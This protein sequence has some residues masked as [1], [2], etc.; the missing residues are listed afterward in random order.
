MTFKTKTSL[1]AAA[2]LT[3]MM[4]AACGGDDGGGEVPVPTPNPNN[5]SN[6]SNPSNPRATNHNG[7]CLANSGKFQ[8]IRLGSRT[9]HRD[10][11]LR[12]GH[13]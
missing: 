1:M 6:P 11:T 5:P 4:L 8:N 12:L 13:F 10:Q 2:A 3:A 7:F 9:I